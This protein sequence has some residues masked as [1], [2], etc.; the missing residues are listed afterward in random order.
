M[1]RL[2][3]RRLGEGDDGRVLV[4]GHSLFRRPGPP[5]LPTPTSAAPVT[6][7]PTATA[8]CCLDSRGVCSGIRSARS[9]GTVA[10]YPAA[11]CTGPGSSAG[12]C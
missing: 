12:G 10:E 5:T 4:N 7:M 9:N 11:L 6:A 2:M 8:T 3:R 1:F